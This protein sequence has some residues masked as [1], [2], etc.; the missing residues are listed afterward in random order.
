VNLDRVQ[1]VV[2]AWEPLLSERGL[3]IAAVVG[4]LVVFLGWRS[5][6]GI[7]RRRRLLLLSLRLVTVGVL[8]LILA[9]PAEVTTKDVPVREPVVLL[10][11]A[12]RSM[13]VEDVDGESRAQAVGRWL[14]DSSASLDE[15]RQRYD[16]RFFLFDDELRPWSDGAAPPTD[17]ASG[18]GSLFDTDGD[19]TADVAPAGGGGPETGEASPADGAG[20]DI[21]GALFGLR[22]RLDGRRPAGVLL[23]SDGADRAAL[24]RASADPER[25]SD[26][27][28]DLLGDLGYPVSVFALGDR[29]GPSDLAVRAVHAPPFG[30]V[31]RPLEISVDLERRAMPAGVV[32]VTLWRDDDLIGSVEVR[33]GVNDSTTVRFEVKPERVGYH[34]Y[35]AVVPTP[36]GDTLPSNNVLERTVKVVRD[37]TRIL[38]V[39]SRPSWDVK[40]LRRLLKTDPNI[41]L[42]S[43]FILR[44]NTISGPLANSE[45][46]SLIEFPYDDLFTT[47]LQ[48]FDL[49]IFQN[50]WFG[51]FSSRSG[52][53]YLNSLADYVRSGGAFLMIGGD[54]SLGAAGYGETPL[55]DVLPTLVPSTASTSDTFRAA[56]TETGRRHPITRLDRNGA[57]NEALWAGL[58]ALQ[59]WN[60]LGP[61]QEGAVALL[62]SGPAESD[63]LIAAARTVEKGR[64]LVLGTDTTW[65]WALGG[66]AGP[67][68][69]M[70]HAEFW[71]N[72]VRWLVKDVEQK[73]VQVLTD[74]ENYR[75]G[76]PIRVQVQVLGQN[77][78]PRS[79]TEVIGTVNPPGDGPGTVFTG[80][81]DSDGQLMA[82]LS[83]DVEGT[84]FITVVVTAIDDPF[85]TAEVRVSVTDREGELEDPAVRPDLLAAVAAAT[86]GR[87]LSGVRPDPSKM[88][89]R[90]LDLDAALD[91]TV[92]P[93]W[94]RPWVLGLLILPLGLEWV[95]R[96]RMGLR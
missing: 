2:F 49:V 77:Y 62:R 61:L 39:T 76:E 37:R 34:T 95:L 17:G 14:L 12:S 94:S 73:Q 53:V 64:T 3:L 70:D 38:Q 29:E 60:P 91:R 24:G 6:A 27:L 1:R 65:R 74:R 90:D 20:T 42:V 8:V 93:L 51:S 56:L 82:T 71:R 88:T 63:A 85:G 89:L 41:D 23:V 66:T 22:D 21:G 45:R 13:R 78:A 58:P 79:G 15:L 33:L 87:V 67:R 5:T 72:A 92:V 75:L 80:V 7:S 4:L 69:G 47:D 57:A 81:T 55:A 26:R 68:A 36:A 54:S 84:H 48:G 83:G 59:G 11:D 25:L 50:F 30:F 19:G 86:G 10:I 96:R 32:P 31:R 16:V 46:L 52:S 28:D 35:R 43:F 9:G 40:F 18:G 44:N